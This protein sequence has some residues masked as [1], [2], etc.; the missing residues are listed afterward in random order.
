MG[1]TR[2]LICMINSP[3]KLAGEYKENKD[4]K[5]AVILVVLTGFIFL[6]FGFTA[7]GFNVTSIFE[8]LGMSVLV[9]ATYFTACL[10]FYI[11]ALATGRRIR[12]N[13]IV[14]TWGF[15]YL[16]TFAVFLYIMLSHLLFANLKLSPSSVIIVISM[17]ILVLLFIWKVIFYFVELIAVM[18]EN[19]AGIIIASIILGVLFVLYYAFSAYILGFKI[20][21][22]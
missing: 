13:E 1:F 6:I 11:A 12:Y 3:H 20:P 22:V 21:I 17:S 18:G 15:S 9:V 4:W 2:I 19:P 7:F 5:P 16:P 8:L 14:S 10:A